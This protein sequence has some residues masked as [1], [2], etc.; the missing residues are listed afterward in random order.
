METINKATE[1]TDD[2]FV[3]QKSQNTPLLA[4]QEDNQ[5]NEHHQT[6]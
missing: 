6:Q 4:E 2:N 3:S 5:P 1:I